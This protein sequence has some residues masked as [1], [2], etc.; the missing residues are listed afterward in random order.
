MT[1][2]RKSNAVKATDALWGVALVVVF[3]LLYTYVVG[4]IYT[5]VWIVG[6]VLLVGLGLVRGVKKCWE[7]VSTP[8][9]PYRD[10]RD[11]LAIV[12]R[13]AEFLQSPA[14]QLLTQ[15]SLPHPKDEIRAAIA[16]VQNA[17][18]TPAGR[19]HLT[20][21]SSK[22]EQRRLLSSEYAAGLNAALLALDDFKPRA[23]VQAWEAL[24]RTAKEGSD[25]ELI[26][27]AKRWQNAQQPQR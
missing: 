11:P 3:L 9:V 18:R 8:K 17:L 20:G 25:A 15:E 21:H 5:V 1:Q 27:L 10:Y 12:Q 4:Y 16:T 23:E 13:Y 24:A 26:A 19:A 14:G 6:I 7:F 2:S 22:S